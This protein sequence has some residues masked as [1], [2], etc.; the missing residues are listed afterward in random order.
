MLIIL[1]AWCKSMFVTQLPNQPLHT[2]VTSIVYNPIKIFGSEFVYKTKSPKNENQK[3]GL[4]PFLVKHSHDAAKKQNKV[5]SIK[6]NY[7]ALNG[8]LLY[9]FTKSSPE[10]NEQNCMKYN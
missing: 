2:Y 8:W 10:M 9:A 5:L 7:Q 3:F 6:F 1:A 4:I